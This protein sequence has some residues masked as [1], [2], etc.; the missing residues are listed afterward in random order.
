MKLTV[1]FLKITVVLTLVALVAIALLPVGFFTWL[2][3]DAFGQVKLI[4]LLM[5]PGLL[6]ASA[7]LIFANYFMGTGKPKYNLYAS[8]VGLA[9]TI[10][11]TLLLIPRMGIQGAAISFSCTYFAII[12]YQWLVFKRL[13]NVKAKELLLTKEDWSWFKEEL[14]AIFA[15]K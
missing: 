13:T 1:Q 6:F 3:S 5:S 2:F 7:Q 9:V 10:P 12:L 14:F 8:L 15:K 4:I 11:I